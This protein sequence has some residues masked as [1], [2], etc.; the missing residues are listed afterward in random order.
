MPIYEYRCRKCRRRTQV[1][2][3]RSTEKVD[4]A[5]DHCG[6]R[7]L[8]RLISRFSVA[9]SDESRL[10]SLSD[11]SGLGDVDEGDPRSMARWMRRMGRE[12]G[13]EVGGADFD[14]MVDRL[15]SGEEAGPEADGDG[16]PDPTGDGEA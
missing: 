9:R 13:D 10:E 3:L 12:M 6:A 14:E 11:P 1:L 8:D 4:A 16:G 15:E 7:D 2:T 5:C